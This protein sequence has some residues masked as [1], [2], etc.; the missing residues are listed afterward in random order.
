MLT[1]PE[2]DDVTLAFPARALDWM[3]EMEDI[4]VEFVE[5]TT[6]WSKIAH[7]WFYD[8]L[9]PETEFHAKEG[10]DAQAAFRAAS[11]T[12]RSFAPKH[13]HKMAAVAYM[14][15]QWFDRIENWKQ[16]KEN[17]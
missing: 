11:A 2:I 13:E 14:L 1:I 12:L 15:S 7:A 8:G 3:P 5:E 17:N 10:V 6:E 16:P 9:S 4:P